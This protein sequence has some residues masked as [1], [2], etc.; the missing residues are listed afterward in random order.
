MSRLAHAVILLNRAGWRGSNELIIPSSTTLLPL[1]PRCPELNP[2]ET[3]WQFM[4]GT[5][6][7][8]A[9]TNLANSLFVRP[10]WSFDV[11]GLV[12]F[13]GMLLVIA[14]MAVNSGIARRRAPGKN[15]RLE[16]GLLTV[17]RAF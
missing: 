14:I 6:C 5:G 4:R 3:L 1:P 2:V 11:G 10:E 15:G 9:S 16:P 12:A 13:W 8:T 7:R 17:A